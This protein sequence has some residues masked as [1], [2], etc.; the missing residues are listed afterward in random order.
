MLRSSLS[1]L[2]AQ[3]IC[4]IYRKVTHYRCAE[5][6]RNFRIGKNARKAKPCFVCLDLNQMFLNCPS[7]I[8]CRPRSVDNSLLRIGAIES[9]T[10]QSSLNKRAATL[11]IASRGKEPAQIINMIT[12]TIEAV[13]LEMAKM[14]L[15]S[16][17]RELVSI[18]SLLNSAFEISF[19][20]N[21]EPYYGDRE[22]T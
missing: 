20:T 7:N 18:C 21:S 9:A 3:Y 1:K 15:I 10:P 14:K 12:A 6:Y 13:L 17:W 8:R 11:E 5:S 4:S 16:R 2:G 19:V 22:S